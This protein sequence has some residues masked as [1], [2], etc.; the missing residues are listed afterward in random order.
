MA[1]QT[2]STTDQTVR[3]VGYLLDDYFR[4]TLHIVSV[5]TAVFG[6]TVFVLTYLFLGSPGDLPMPPLQ[7]AMFIIG[8]GAI[9]AAASIKFALRKRRPRF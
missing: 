7:K 8:G 5:A 6:V 3:R 4:R 2:E 1:Q 9:L